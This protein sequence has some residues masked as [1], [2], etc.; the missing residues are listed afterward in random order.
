MNAMHIHCCSESSS[1]DRSRTSSPN[2]RAPSRSDREGTATR[3]SEFLRTR[4]K[5]SLFSSHLFSFSLRFIA[6]L[7]FIIKTQP[8]C[9]P[10]VE[11]ILFFHTHVSQTNFPLN[12]HFFFSY[13]TFFCICLFYLFFASRK[14]LIIHHL[15]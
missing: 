7:P 9:T 12:I 13:Y 6:L 14:I 15:F 2:R 8:V 11:I 5:G 3:K 10:G 1:L 4:R